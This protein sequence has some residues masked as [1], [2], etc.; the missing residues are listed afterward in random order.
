MF[1]HFRQNSVLLCAPI[2]C[3]GATL[4][5]PQSFDGEKKM[6]CWSRNLNRMKKMLGFTLVELLVVIAI[7][8]V[9]IALLLPAVQMAREAARATQC[10]NNLKQIG[11]AQQNAHDVLGRFVPG[12]DMNIVGKQISRDLTPGWGLLIM[13]YMEMTSLYE[14]KD[15][16]G[17]YGLIDSYGTAGTSNTQNRD[18]VNTLIPGFLCPSA[19]DIPLEPITYGGTTPRFK[20]LDNPKLTRERVE[21][22]SQ[23]M[24]FKGSRSHYAPVHGAQESVSDRDTSPPTKPEY[25]IVGGA[26]T[27]EGAGCTESC[28]PS[29]MMP[30]IQRNDFT[31]MY[32]DVTKVTD[33]LSNTVMITEDAC[34]FLSLWSHHFC[35]LCWKRTHAAPVNEKPFVPLSA[36]AM[37]PTYVGYSAFGTSG[38]YGFHD[39]RSFHPGGAF[40][41]YGDGRV[42]ALGPQTDMDVIFNLL[43]IADDKI[44]VLP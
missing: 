5:L 21:F 23:N 41:V 22:Y 40:S 36:K 27:G 39:I 20:Y 28:K 32:V 26:T 2:V 10:K 24:W 9:L 30:A 13:P 16:S 7:I 25:R 31:S 33:G 3:D 37:T 18:L 38:V 17:S 35:L 11:L 44:V 34:S 43:R 42:S 19:S 4:G 6:S 1:P 12:G 8:A 29:G 15:F 14:T